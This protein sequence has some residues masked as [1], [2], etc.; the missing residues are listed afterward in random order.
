MGGSSSGGGGGGTGSSSSFSGPTAGV[1]IVD[2]NFVPASITVLTGTMVTWNNT[3][4]VTHTV[5]C[6][7]GPDS[8]FYSGSISP[9]QSYSIVLTNTGTNAYYCTI[10]GFTGIAIVTN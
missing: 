4:A 2:F 8:L 6:T 1:S 9:G 5:K 7:N 3:G 10:H